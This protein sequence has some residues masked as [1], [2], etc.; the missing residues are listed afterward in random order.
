MNTRRA[1]GLRGFSLLEALVAMAIASIAFAVLYRT[2][3]QS[4][5]NATTVESRAE[6]ALVARSVLASATF[7]EDLVQ[8]PEGQSGPWQ[9]SVQV[10]PE[11]VAVHAPGARQAPPPL[12]A[13]RVELTIA[14][15]GRAV[16]A[17]TSWKPYRAAP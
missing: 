13:A 12:Q 10:Q 3:G 4:S 11:Q 9:W 5:L 6:A 17:W 14:R 15:D 8:H 7:A 16:L 1:R 2:V